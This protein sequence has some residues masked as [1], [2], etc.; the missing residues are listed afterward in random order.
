MKKLAL[1][2]LMAVAV[3]SIESDIC[4]A[5]GHNVVPQEYSYT[6]G[7][8]VTD[9]MTAPITYDKEYRDWGFRAHSWIS[10]TGSGTVAHTQIINADNGQVMAELHVPC[11]Y[12]TDNDV[13]DNN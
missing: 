6:E 13:H 8:S 1:A 4:L 9:T 3:I 7:G 12:Q 5:A 2:A 10:D 11:A